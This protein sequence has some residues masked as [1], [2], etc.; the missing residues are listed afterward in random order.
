MAGFSKRNIVLVS[1]VWCRKKGS[2]QLSKRKYP[3]ESRCLRISWWSAVGTRRY[4]LFQGRQR[5]L[6]RQVGL[7]SAGGINLELCAN[8]KNI[9]LATKMECELGRC[10]LWRVYREMG[11]SHEI[12]RDLHVLRASGERLFESRIVEYRRTKRLAPGSN[13][14][15]YIRI[16]LSKC[17]SKRDWKKRERVSQFCADVDERADASSGDPPESDPEPAGSPGVAFALEIKSSIE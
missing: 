5:G 10:S 7:T 14:A 12:L 6:S 15:L 11:R 9:F 1:R 16:Q 3:V 2:T 13:H 8:I 17:L 4:Q